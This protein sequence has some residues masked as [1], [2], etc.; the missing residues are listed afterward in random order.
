LQAVFHIKICFYSGSVLE[1]DSDTKEYLASL[2][3]RLETQFK[4]L[5]ESIV[6]RDAFLMGS[7]WWI[8]KTC[9]TIF[10]VI[11]AI[12]LLDWLTLGGWMWGVGFW[13]VFIAG[14]TAISPYVDRKHEEDEKRLRHI[15]DWESRRP[16]D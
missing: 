5:K 6:Q 16:Y 4:E 10:V 15:I 1:M 8:I 2:E 11:G 3:G 9:G 7:V 12:K 13:V 14:V